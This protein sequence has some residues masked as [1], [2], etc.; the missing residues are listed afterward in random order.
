MPFS[1]I[2]SGCLVIFQPFVS[3]EHLMLQDPL[4]RWLIYLMFGGLVLLALFRLP[5]RVILWLGKFT[6]PNWVSILHTPLAWIGYFWLYKAGYLF[7]GLELVIFA[8]AL[9]RIDGRMAAVL[10]RNNPAPV[11]A[12]LWG[13]LNYRGN[14]PYGKVIDPMMDKFAVLPIYLDAGF[15]F[16]NGTHQIGATWLLWPLVTSATLIGIMLLM[17]LAGQLLRMDT[18]KK[19]R[20]RQDNGATW[21]GKIKAGA[22]WAWLVFF[23]IWD[24]GWLEDSYRGSFMLFLNAFLLII[25]GL[26]ALSV[27]TKIR[28]VRESWTRIFAHTKR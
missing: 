10:S 13:Q 7:S 12:D 4:V 19:W 14:T 26:A 18:F 15:R 9:D 11:P 22:Q 2:P 6:S 24:Q 23:P 3:K 20:R 28:P 5:E 16:L 8:A 1:Q 25:V 21:A 17:E 27:I